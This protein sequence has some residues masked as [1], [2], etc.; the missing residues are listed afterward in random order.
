ML[1]PRQAI[2]RYFIRFVP[3]MTAY[4]VLLIG[5]NLVR[6][7]WHLGEMATVALAVLPRFPSSR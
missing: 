4:V 7:A 3:S 5:S 2:R 6:R 1:T